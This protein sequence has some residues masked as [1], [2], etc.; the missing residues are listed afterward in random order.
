[1]L[2]SLHVKNMALMQEAEVEFSDGLNILTGETGAGKSLLIGSVNLALGSGNFRDYIAEGADYALTELVFTTDSARVS[3]LLREQDI[4]CEDGELILS[5]RYRDGR[6]VSRINGETVPVSFVR[7][8][9]SELIDIHGQ[10]DSQTLL[11]SRNHLGI[12]DAYAK[13]E[14]ASCA[15]DCREQYRS[16]Q[17]AKRELNKARETDRDRAKE[18][19]F[20]QYE[21]RE[22][23]A[24]A[25]SCG[26]DDE[27]ED[28]YRKMSNS[29]KILE[30]VSEAGSLTG[31]SGYGGAAEEL[32]RAARLLGSVRDCDSEIGS[33]FDSIE[34]AESLITDFNRSLSEYS[35]S[36]SFDSRSFSRTE[37]RLDLINS[38]KSKYG[39]SI[40]EIL[41][42]CREK[43]ERISLLE[44]YES[45]LDTLQRDY[46]SAEAA[47]QKTAQALSDARRKSAA[48]F[49]AK[50]TEALE[51]LNFLDVRFEI[52]ILRREEPS[53]DGIDDVSFL[54]SMNPGM[55]LR[56]LSSVASGGE[57]SRIMLAIKAVMADRDNIETLI[58]DEIDA[59]ISGRTA[60]KVSEKLAL[61]SRSH[62]V[63]CIT[64]L[65]QI[66][67]MADSH[68]L[69][70]KKPADSETIT[71]IALLDDEQ[72]VGELARILGGAKI[73]DAVYENAREMKELARSLKEAEDL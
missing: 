42:S 14:V 49:A 52:D 24:A 71:K 22:I 23:Q 1:M 56:P 21:V 13:E 28:A 4:P 41:D 38:L 20:L 16:M 58:F 27:L 36:L 2:V 39:N 46:E 65:A 62:Q 64:H 55:P 73:T 50:I 19:D 43:E 68:Y 5:R 12:L 61:I 69:I 34:D 53:E 47:Y 31:A 67:S 44:N 18:L 66:A 10:Q 59:G 51:D 25:L 30:A 9:A 33:L 35:E 15:A 70:E 54:I 72:S 8:I 37:E 45:Y 17:K 60:Q 26:E 63:L 48:V 6:T 7:Q 40:E 29:E 57:L 32:D 3:E 11:S